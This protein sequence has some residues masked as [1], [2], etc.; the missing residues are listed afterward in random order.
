MWQISNLVSLEAS[1]PASYN[2][3]TMSARTVKA[4]LRVPTS[5][6]GRVGFGVGVALV[7]REL[8]MTLRGSRRSFQGQV[9]VITGGGSGIGRL[10]A[11]IFAKEGASVALWDLNLEGAESV[12]AECKAAAPRGEAGWSSMARAYRVDVSDR[13][14]VEETAA[15]TLADFGGRVDI[16]INNA[17]IVAG[18][19]LTDAAF[20]PGRASK[21]IEINTTALMWSTRAFLPQM[22]ARDSGHVVTVAS[23]AGMA[24]TAGLTDYCASK[25]GAVGFDEVSGATLAHARTR[26]RGR[27]NRGH[28]P[29]RGRRADAR[30]SQTRAR[31]GQALVARL[32]RGFG[33]DASQERGVGSGATRDG[34]ATRERTAGTNTCAPS[35]GEV[36]RE[37]K[38]RA[39]PPTAL[40]PARRADH[41]P[42]PPR[43][44]LRMELRTRGS[45]VCTT[46]VSPYY[47]ATGMFQVRPV[48]CAESRRERSREVASTV[49]VAS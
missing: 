38:T 21:V 33:A 7:L 35:R 44:A 1:K 42:P 9:V 39:D 27:T 10:M 2:V 36:R 16:L 41:P 32:S 45:G 29:N 46:R 14:V 22:L 30:S 37:Q 11:I 26:T 5:S 4:L 23:A 40:R 3:G 28:P 13:A 47:I 49:T 6:P 31:R 12:A 17:G 15:R 48:E 24:G 34:G 25:F 8:W 43:Q 20:S 19:K 18:A